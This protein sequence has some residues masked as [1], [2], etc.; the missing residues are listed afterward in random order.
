MQYL[1]NVHKVEGR[2]K[3]DMTTHGQVNRHTEEEAVI[4]HSWT[5]QRWWKSPMLDRTFGKKSK[6]S[7]AELEGRTF[8]SSLDPGRY[9]YAENENKFTSTLST[10]DWGRNKMFCLVFK[11]W[12][13]G[14]GRMAMGERLVYYQSAAVEGSLW[15]CEVHIAELHFLSDDYNTAKASPWITSY[16]CFIWYKQTQH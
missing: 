5:S 13:H 4:I 3:R 10:E 11:I 2:K 7:P 8:E 14:F 16:Q 12:Q 6:S 9:S 15:A 1:K